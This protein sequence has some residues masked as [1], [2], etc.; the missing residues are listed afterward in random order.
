MNLDLSQKVVLVSG[1]SRGLGRAIATAFLQEGASVIITGRG[2]RDVLQTTK[3]LTQVSDPTT[4]L[5]FV[6]DLRKTSDI[7]RC[8]KLIQQRFKRLDI[9]VANI[10]S[11]RGEKGWEAPES[12]W[13]RLLELNLLAPMR[14]IRQAIPLLKSAKGASIVLISSIAGVEAIGGPLAY[15]TSKAGLLQA[16]KLLSRELAASGIRVNVVAPG[17]ILFPGSVW[18]DKL[19]K[20]RREVMKYVQST[21]P[22]KRFAKPEEIA[23]VVA[24]VSSSRAGFMTGSCVVVDGGQ[25][26]CY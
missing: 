24:F 16:S 4:V 15:G 19:K 8:L 5:G 3:E 9:V 7:Q 14:L 1:S 2:Q 10:G 26:H 13:E 11:G 22:M 17:N 20:N 18:A 23:N 21:V 25:T 6:G 12:T